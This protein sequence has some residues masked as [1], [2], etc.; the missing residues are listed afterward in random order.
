MNLIRDPWIPIRRRSGRD[1]YIAPWQITDDL[2]GDPVVALNA[3]RP[4]FN[5][6]LAQFLIGLFQTVMPPEGNYDYEWGVL[7]DEPPDPSTLRESLGEFESAFEFDGEGP[8]FMQDFERIEGEVKPVS[9][10]LLE[11]PGGQTLRLNTDHFIKRGAVDG[12]C[13]RC[14]AAALFSLQT[15][16]PSGG[17]GHRTSMRGGGPL[18]TLIVPSESENHEDT[19]LWKLIWLNVMTRHQTGELSG[20][21]AKNTPSDIFPWLGPIHSSEKKTGR[22]TTPE[23]VNPLQMYWGMP[24]RIRLDFS[25]LEDGIC[26]ICGAE[27]KVIR[28]YVTK[29]YGINYDSVVENPVFEEVV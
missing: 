24:R 19:L 17:A 22:D 26:G 11:N 23:D 14:A 9:A 25:G 16:A 21:Q 15:N 1:E 2:E 28:S 4:D 20:N 10:L 5:G 7:Y 18:S 8:R 12:L 6:S 29:N 3:P 13:H 27:E